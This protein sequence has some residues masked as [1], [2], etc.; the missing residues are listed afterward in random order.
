MSAAIKYIQNSKQDVSVTSFA[1]NPPDKIKDW[2]CPKQWV[3]DTSSSKVIAQFR[4]CN[5]RLGNRGP[6]RNGE[7]Y[8]LCPLCAKSGTVALNNEVNMSWYV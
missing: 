1:M 7:F 2:F 6:A 4:S 5:V 3:N 8:R